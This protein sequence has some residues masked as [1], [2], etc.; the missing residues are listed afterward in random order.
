MTDDLARLEQKVYALVALVE[1]LREANADLVRDVAAAREQNRALAQRMQAA[2]A[3]LDALIARLPS[4][5][6]QP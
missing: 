4:D 1:E 5:L 2:S 6:V 3:R